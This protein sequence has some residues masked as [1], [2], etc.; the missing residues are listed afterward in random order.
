MVGVAA[1][2]VPA[3]DLQP[4]AQ[5]QGVTG[6]DGVGEASKPVT[7]VRLAASRTSTR[8]LS[9]VAGSAAVVPS[10]S[11]RHQP[12]PSAL[13]SAEKRP[14]PSVVTQPTRP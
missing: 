7:R 13:S 3:V 1:P 5:A 8:S 11:A 10:N 12:D 9:L 4:A 2:E 6:P 14:R